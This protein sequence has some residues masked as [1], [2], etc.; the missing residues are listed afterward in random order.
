M[1]VPSDKITIYAQTSGSNAGTPPTLKSLTYH[2]RDWFNSFLVNP[3]TVTATQIATVR[4]V[5]ENVVALAI[6]PRLSTQ[7]EQA[8]A[9]AGKEPLSKDYF[10]DSA[11]YSTTGGSGGSA[12]PA[13]T[14][15]R[16]QDPQINPV[17]QLPPIVTV[18]MLAIDERS[19]QRWAT[20][21]GTAM[22]DLDTAE[23][24]FTDSTKLFDDPTTTDTAGD[25]DL[26]KLQ[27]FLTKQ[28]L[29]YRLFSANVAIRGAKWSRQQTN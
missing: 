28:K 26:D 8:R 1:R 9:L 18:A 17:N 15:T 23:N 14:S 2:A 3:T 20:I 22:P 6:L 16:Y 27:T 29:T 21:N 4:T 12:P 25:G 13:G 10:Y 5:A 11:Y 7:E 24:L 19:A